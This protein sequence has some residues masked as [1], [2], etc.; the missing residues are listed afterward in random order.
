[1][2]ALAQTHSA[3]S[4][5]RAPMLLVVEDEA[6]VR[7]MLAEA[8][9]DAGFGVLEAADAD[10]ALAILENVGAVDAMITDVHMPGALDGVALA[11]AARQLCPD[12]KLILVSGSARRQGC[13]GVADVFFPKPYPLHDVVAEVQ[14]LLSVD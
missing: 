9:R 12:A 8:I 6:L 4:A 1:M 3:G 5:R 2:V 11:A 14:R 10:E 13:D 7:F